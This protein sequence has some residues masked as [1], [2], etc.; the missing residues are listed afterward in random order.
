MGY[1]FKAHIYLDLLR[2]LFTIYHYYNFSL[3]VWLEE[4]SIF[5]NRESSNPI[6]IFTFKGKSCHLLQWNY[7][8]VMQA[9]INVQKIR[10]IYFTYMWRLFSWPMQL[11]WYISIY[12]KC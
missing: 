4:F 3:M 2:N 12:T 9:S 7:S 5:D 1:L 11:R 10:Y 6:L 8:P